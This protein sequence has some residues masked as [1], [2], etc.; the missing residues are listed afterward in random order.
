MSGKNIR[1]IV[2]DNIKK[3]RTNNE[4]SQEELAFRAKIHRTYIG[5]IERSEKNISIEYLDKIA[6]ALK[7]SIADLVTDV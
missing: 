3:Y 6:K 2:A 7:V 4:I 1:Q 5:S